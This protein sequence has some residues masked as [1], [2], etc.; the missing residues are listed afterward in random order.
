LA[1]GEYVVFAQKEGYLEGKIEG[2]KI[3]KAD[4]P[5]D[6]K[7]ISAEFIKK[8]EAAGL[9]AFRQKDFKTAI[10]HYQT[11]LTYTPNS[12]MMWANIAK[13]NAL[14]AEWEPALNAAQKA[15]SF[16]PQF[17]DLGTQLEVLS[18][19]QKGQDALEKKNFSRAETEL[20][21]AREMGP[22]NPMY[23][24]VLYTLS[25]AYGHQKKYDE[26]FKACEEAIK[27]RPT[28]ASFTDLLRII[29]NN[30]AAAKK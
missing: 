11:I 18:H 14:L 24:D 7:L 19:F 22:A 4:I 13:A 9:A 30:A 2:I 6:L 23:P 3:E 16:D 21:K 1:A 27:L 26:A 15:A 25:L 5:L 10:S 20:L 8:E 12:A 28:D 29:K 17:K